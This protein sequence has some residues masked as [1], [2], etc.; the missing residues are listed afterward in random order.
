MIMRIFLPWIIAT[1]LLLL[2]TASPICAKDDKQVLVINSYHQGFAWSDRVLSGSLGGL[3]LD[4]LTQYRDKLF[5]AGSVDKLPAGGVVVNRPESIFDAHREFVVC[6]LAALAILGSLVVF[7]GMTIVRRRRAE[8]ALQ[9]TQ[10]CVDKSPMAFARINDN[11]RLEAVNEAMCN[12]LGY[13]PEELCSMTVFD[14]DSSFTPDRFKEHRGKVREAGYRVIE[15]VHRRKDGSTFPVEVTVN[16]VNYKGRNVSYSFTK[17]I[18][19][20]KLAEDALRESE[21]RLAEIIDFLPDATFAIDTEGKV[22]AW[23]RAI[24]EMFGVKSEDMLGK[25]DH[26]YSL[27]LYGVRRPMLIDLVLSPNDEIVKE[28]HSVRHEGAVLTAETTVTLRDE[29]LYLWGKAVALYD[30]LGNLSGAIESIR[31]ITEQRH[32][33]FEQAKLRDLLFQSQKMETVG[34]LAGGVAHDFNNLLT[35]ILGYSE[36]MLIGVSGSDPNRMMIEQIQQ[37]AERARELTKRLLAF[38][39]K[40]M[41]ELIVISLGEI[42]RDFEPVLHRTIRENIVININIEPSTGM[43]RVDKGQIE[44]ALLNL[45]LNAQDAMPDGGELTIE[46]KNFEVDENYMVTHLEVPPGPYVMLCV[47]DTGVGMDADVQS[48]IFEPFFTTK[49]LGKGTGLGLATVYGILKQHGGAISVYSEKGRGSIFKA[50]LPRV[51]EAG[52]RAA[53]SP[54]ASDHVERGRET[55][56]VVE[57]NETV[58]IL[59]CKILKDLGYNVLTAGSV[60]GCIEIAVGHAGPIDL[61]LTDVIMPGM[62]GKELYKTLKRDRP[63]IKALFMSGYTDNVIGRHGIIDEGVN[64]LQKPFSIAALSQKVRSSLDS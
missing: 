45:A 33:D 11:G 41:L 1:G 29:Q 39:R 23:N 6:I 3:P 13:T 18:T 8:E 43:V 16:Q 64:F 47:S 53:V 28:Y 14:F 57:D 22:I 40:Q 10:L 52:K 62:N 15:T 42:I 36:M 63:A 30:S 24:E 51:T 4:L 46:A 12:N 55:V 7:F 17:D 54:F 9:L 19:G 48:H 50:L 26:E 27:P 49:E 34:L 2:F 35:P 21:K 59:T 20:R 61:L 44:Q 31:D 38:S 56:L 60:D 5:S 32:A 37:C 25:G 58:R